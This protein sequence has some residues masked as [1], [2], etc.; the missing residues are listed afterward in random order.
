VV[1]AQHRAKLTSNAELTFRIDL[2]VK[3]KQS[4]RP[5]AILDTKYKA[6]ELPTE[7]DIQ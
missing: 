7:A 6:T 1:T 5:I 3:D 2:L 4:G